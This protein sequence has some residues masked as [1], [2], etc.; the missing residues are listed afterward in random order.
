MDLRP[1]RPADRTACLAVFD[2]N[3]APDRLKFEDFLQSPEG[4]YFV[5]E[6]DG[7]IIGC[8]GYVLE[9]DQP[10]ASLV[11]GMIRRDSHGQGLGRFLLMY[12]LREISKSGRIDRVRLET[13]PPVAKFFEGQGFRIV[14]EVND[15]VEMVKKLTVCS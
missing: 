13:S 12:R 11:W 4:P 2:S 10:V 14:G 15:R 8:G 3:S 7:E 1:Y 9:P 6:H 5:M